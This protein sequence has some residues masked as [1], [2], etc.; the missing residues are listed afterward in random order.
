MRIVKK[1][2]NIRSINSNTEEQIGQAMDGVLAYNLT[3]NYKNI[4]DGMD[5][6]E[7]IDE[8]Y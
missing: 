8:M 7:K 1:S 4:I 6:K 5:K 2:L 3:E